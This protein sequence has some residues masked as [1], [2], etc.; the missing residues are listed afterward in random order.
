MR[1]RMLTRRLPALLL[2][3]AAGQVALASAAG[4][5]PGLLGLLIPPPPPPAVVQPAQATAAPA[6]PPLL[7]IEKKLAELHYDVGPV[8]GNVDEQTISAILAFQKVYGLARTG[9]LT[10]P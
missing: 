3:V 2:T 1:K 5:A 7:P 8:D 9:G 10:D 4:A 6:T